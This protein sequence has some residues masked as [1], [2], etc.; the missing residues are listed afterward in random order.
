VPAL[1]AFLE[2][3]QH[4]VAGRWPEAIEAYGTA[5][6]ADSSFW[7]AGWR[8]NS[9]H[10][11]VLGA[12]PDPDL[13]RGYE[14]HLSAFGERD[15]L[16]IELGR[17]V[18]L[19][20]VEW[21]ARSRAIADRFPD[22]WSAWWQYADEL[23][24]W[25]PLI[26]YTNADAR[27]AL[28]RTV[29]LNPKLVPMWDHLF[30]ASIGHDSVQAA[31][32][33][34]TLTALGNGRK[35]QRLLLSAGGQL[36]VPLR[37]SVAVEV[38][39]SPDWIKRALASSGLYIHGYPGA[40]IELNRRLIA[41]DPH[42][43]LTGFVWEGMAQAWAARGAWDSALVAYQRAASLRT[44]DVSPVRVYAFAVS[45]A[46]LGALDTARAVKHRT[47]AVQYLGRLPPDSAGTKY[48]QAKLAWADGMVAVLRRDRRGLADAR[49]LARNS[50]GGEAPFM[51]RSLAGFELELAGAK[52]AAAESL[53]ALDLAATGSEI[54][55]RHDGYARSITHL[56][57]SRLLLEQGDTTRALKLLVW[58]EANIP[59][60]AEPFRSQ[61]F[62]GLA[63]HELARIEE[64]QGKNDLARDHY[65]QF[66]R[67]YD[68]PP[69][70]Q[71]YL[72]DSAKASLRRLSGQRDT[73]PLSEPIE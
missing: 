62:A 60:S 9:A 70:A 18:S 27:A 29:D 16:L 14:A 72:V 61:F 10:G 38:A 54:G 34:K 17:E 30:D 19:P 22:D 53:A 28:Q 25:G 59:A 39:R 11:W 42:E 41:L 67:R 1:R 33:L 55:V 68:M 58:H 64:A 12:H 4:L 44:H 66:L 26:G 46:L 65:E 6:K 45:G 71:Q 35:Y 24:H 69:P 51:A 20:E 32:A 56:A 49:A 52:R 8:Y 21:A 63:Y 31:L 2:G 23:L 15:R 43:P 73:P 48:W 57:A 50:G 47:A 40:Q 36:P 3:E 7:L 13:T 37:D 5:I